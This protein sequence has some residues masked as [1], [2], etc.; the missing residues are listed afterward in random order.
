M[1]MHA[2]RTFSV[3]PDGHRRR[4]GAALKDRKQKS[5][6]TTKWQGAREA[7][8]GPIPQPRN[9]PGKRTQ[10][11]VSARRMDG[12]LRPGRSARVWETVSIRCSPASS[13]AGDP[14]YRPSQPYTARSERAS[15]RLVVSLDAERA[16]DGR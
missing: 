9:D 2:P 15:G 12:P 7:D 16:A 8:E 14:E 3:P 4:R 11:T 6:G 10:V 1:S 13:A 5:I